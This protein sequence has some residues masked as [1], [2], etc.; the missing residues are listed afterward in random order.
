MTRIPFKAIRKRN[1]KEGKGKT[2]VVSSALSFSSCIVLS[3][4]V[5]ISNPRH[6]SGITYLRPNAFLPLRIH[7][8]CVR[9]GPSTHTFTATSP[10]SSSGWLNARTHTHHISYKWDAKEAKPIAM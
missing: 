8:D 7:S 9:T 3:T 10:Q 1:E 2:Q 5:A 4:L 6:L